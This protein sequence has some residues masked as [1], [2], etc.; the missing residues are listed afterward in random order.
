MFTLYLH[1]L[2]RLLALFLLIFLSPLFVILYILV[3]FT[4][5]GPFLFKQLRAGKN[6]KPFWIYKIRTMVENA[7]S[8][9]EKI[10][11]LN[12]ADGPVFKVYD[13]PRFTKIGRFL[14]KIGIDEL[15]QLI[16]IVKGQMSFVGPR[17]L[18]LDEAK[19][20]PKKYKKRFSVLPGIFSS[21]VAYGA[22]HNDFKKW[23]ELDLKDVE[24]K[25]F[26]YDLKIVIKS[27][28]FVLKLVIR[29]VKSSINV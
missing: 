2:E 19:K 22:F 28:G 8:L 7:E 15:P 20:I 27:L 5:Q 4:S 13:D 29:S 10:K 12:Q 9:K 25:S 21:W 16:N 14:A 1:F 6:K 3:K 18:P 23:M 24:N 26:W 11:H 17:P